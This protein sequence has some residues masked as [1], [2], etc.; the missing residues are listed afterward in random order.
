MPHPG[1]PTDLQAPFMALMCLADSSSTIT[2]NL[3]ENRFLHVPELVRMGAKVKLE[4]HSAIISGNCKLQ[5]AQVQATD[6]RAERHSF[7]RA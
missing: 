4:G 7:G 2:E 3:F 1:F 6:L 5:G